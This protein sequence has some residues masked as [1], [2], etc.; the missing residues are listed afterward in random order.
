MIL[1]GQRE[2]LSRAAGAVA[3]AALLV[4]LWQL[5]HMRWGPLVLPAPLDSFRVLLQMLAD[6]TIAE[7]AARTAANALGGFAAGA[8]FGTAL[9]MA[10]GLSRPLGLVLGPFVTIILGVPPIAWV[11]LALLWFGSGGMGAI[12]VVVVTTFPLVFAAAVQSVRTFDPVIGEMARSF[13]ARPSQM[14]FKLRLPHA[15]AYLYPALATGHGIAWKAAVM[16][17]VLSAG[18]GIGERLALARANLDTAEAMALVVLIVGL[19]L[20]VDGVVLDPFRRRIERW[21]PKA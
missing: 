4:V 19:L 1:R 18:T 2:R 16:A 14:L 13:G 7:P 20:L 6:G 8:L 21:R 5:V 11:V 17:E 3:G 10:A 15:V 12:A 9:G